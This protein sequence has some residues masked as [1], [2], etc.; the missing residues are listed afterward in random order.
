MYKVDLKAVQRLIM[1][2]VIPKYVKDSKD[3]VKEYE[4]MKYEMYQQIPEL[5]Q[6]PRCQWFAHPRLSAPIH[7][8]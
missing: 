6:D 3:G 7:T 8:I 2:I 1:E 5:T 4:A